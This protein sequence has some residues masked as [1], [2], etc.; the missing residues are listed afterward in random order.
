MSAIVPWMKHWPANKNGWCHHKGLKE[1]IAVS[2]I[3]NV[4]GTWCKN[5]PVNKGE[6]Q[7][8][9]STADFPAGRYFVSLIVD[10]NV[11]SNKQIIKS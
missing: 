7:I 4:D 2:S 6:T 10:G 8:E 5:I 1:N 11:I 3:A 9:V